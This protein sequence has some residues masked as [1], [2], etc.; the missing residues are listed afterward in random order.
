MVLRLIFLL[1]MHVF[2]YQDHLGEAVCSLSTEEAVQVFIKFVLL[3]A[4]C[5]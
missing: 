5:V 2:V 3:S 1:Y 4:N